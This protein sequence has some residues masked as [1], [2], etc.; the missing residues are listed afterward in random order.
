MIHERSYKTS[1]LTSDGIVHP[2]E[3]FDFI[4]VIT[5]DKILDGN[6]QI[7]LI[8]QAKVPRE[9]FYKPQIPLD[10]EIFSSLRAE[11]FSDVKFE[12][13]GKIFL[14]HKC[15]VNTRSEV[16]SEILGGN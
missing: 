9:H 2:N 15:I 1:I 10:D 5:E 11:H 3:G 8:F 7:E 13:E 4:E 12:V 6:F 16:L 14:E